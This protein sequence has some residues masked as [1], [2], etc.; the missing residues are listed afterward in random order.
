MALVLAVVRLVYALGDHK[1][2]VGAGLEGLVGH[3]VYAIWQFC[4]LWVFYMALEPL[5]R[6]FWPD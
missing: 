4:F 2:S 6:R 5:A 1:F 3:L